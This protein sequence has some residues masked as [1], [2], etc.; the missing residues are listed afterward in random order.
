MSGHEFG[1]VITYDYDGD[2]ADWQ[3]AVDGFIADID[4]DPRLKGRF[5]YQVNR[6][7]EGPGRI[8]IGRWDEPE[9][10]AHLQGQDFFKAF[11][12]KV[13]EFAGGAPNATRFGKVAGTTGT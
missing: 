2:E 12:G 10:L 8:H 9:T 4:A 11:A 1:I 3:A 5:T 7:L 6:A 13:G